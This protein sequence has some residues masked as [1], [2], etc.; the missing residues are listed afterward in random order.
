KLV[1]SHPV[2]TPMPSTVAPGQTVTVN[3]NVNALAAGSY[4][5]DFDMYSGATGSSPVAFS[6]QGIP[7]FAMGL[8]VPQPPPVVSSVYPPTGYV[9]PTL[10]P[11]LS[12]VASTKSGTITYS[13]T[14]TCNPLPG[15]TCP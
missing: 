9:S 1:A 7:P 14:V 4:A 13:F 10:T 11:Q 6:S 8:Y 12:T 2:F 3:A 5:I 15:Q